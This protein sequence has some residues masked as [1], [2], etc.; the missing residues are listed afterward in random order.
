MKLESG[1]RGNELRE[2]VRS[3]EVRQGVRSDELRGMEEERIEGKRV[4]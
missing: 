1:V 2:G 3:G 4:R